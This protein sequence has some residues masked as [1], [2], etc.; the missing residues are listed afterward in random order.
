MIGIYRSFL[1]QS[2]AAETEPARPPKQAKEQAK[3]ST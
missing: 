2:A 3:R 1:A